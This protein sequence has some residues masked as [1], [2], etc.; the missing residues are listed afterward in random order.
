MSPELR[1]AF[2]A[3]KRLLRYIIEMEVQEVFFLC[4]IEKLL[5]MIGLV[6]MLPQHLYV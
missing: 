6:D 1:V 4:F 5:V 2:L 3:F